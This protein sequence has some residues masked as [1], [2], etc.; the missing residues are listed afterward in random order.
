MSSDCK[1]HDEATL[2]PWSH[3]KPLAWVVAALNKFAQSYISSTTT[4][5]GVTADIVLGFLLRNQQV[6]ETEKP[7]I[8]L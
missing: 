2:I 6:H 4:D 1:I 7:C 8:N 5:A 3:D